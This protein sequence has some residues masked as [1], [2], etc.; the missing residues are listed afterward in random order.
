MHMVGR[1]VQVEQLRSDSNI[2]LRVPSKSHKDKLIFCV[3]MIL[4][5]HKIRNIISQT[6]WSDDTHERNE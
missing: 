1:E 6:V 3:S 4:L 5:K 2:N